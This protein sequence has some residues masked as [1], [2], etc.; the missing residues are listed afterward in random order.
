MIRQIV[1]IAA[2]LVLQVSAQQPSISPGALVGSWSLVSLERTATGEAPVHP[3]G[4][5]VVGRLTYEVDGRMSVMLGR[6]DR[7]KFAV[8][9][10]GSGGTTDEI[11]AAFQGFVAYYGTYSLNQEKK[12]VTHTIEFSSLP[13]W[14]GTTQT[15]TVEMSGDRLILLNKLVADGKQVEDRLVWKRLP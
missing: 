4:V 9:P 7:P 2:F 3:M 14:V 1:L 8:A 10:G 13:S 11:R 15:R 6:R 12:Q 5:D